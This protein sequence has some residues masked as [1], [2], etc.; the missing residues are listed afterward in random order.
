[1]PQIV[2]PFPSVN[3]PVVDQKGMITTPWLTLF[4]A[5]WERTGAALGQ[6]IVPEGTVI[7]Y[8]GDAVPIGWLLCNGQAISRTQYLNLF[9]IIGTVWGVGDG[10]NTFNVPNLV[11]SF[12]R[13]GAVPGAIGGNDSTT[14]A[15]DNLPPHTHTTVAAA[16]THVVN[17][18]GHIHAV[19]DAGHVHVV[20]D[21]GH[22]HT[23]TDPG[24]VHVALVA[25][26]NVT[27]GIVA[28]GVIAGNIAS[29]TTGITVDS[30]VTGI[31][32][33]NEVT[34]VSIDNEVTGITLGSTDTS[35]NVGSTGSGDSFSN[36]PKYA[37]L[38][39]LIKT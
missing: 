32:V 33:D 10:T 25:D 28:G 23:V 17:D 34:G 2:Q 12:A 37:T 4:K 36:L 6:S 5:V 1:M 35:I 27:V 15:V 16:H 14:L 38:L 22:V 29:A 3:S 7:S 21:P 30:E 11:G 13:G 8:A 39:M 9:R 26:S 24:H 19:T 18:A 20:T 31:T